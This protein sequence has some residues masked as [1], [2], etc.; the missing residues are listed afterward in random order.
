MCQENFWDNFSRE[1]KKIYK[2][3]F[4]GEYKEQ[5]KKL[6]E[7]DKVDIIDIV[8]PKITKQFENIL[9]SYVENYIEEERMRLKK[10]HLPL[11]EVN[12]EKTKSNKRRSTNGSKR[13]NKK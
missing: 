8:V 10:L 9:K 7:D 11:F 4:D 6:L 13:T 1:M 12:E 3:N 2:F 5:Y